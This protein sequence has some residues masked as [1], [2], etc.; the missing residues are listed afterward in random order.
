MSDNKD[1]RQQREEVKSNLRKI[2]KKRWFYPAVYLCAAALIMTGVLWLQ[3]S[4]SNN[5]A[6][7][8][9]RMTLYTSK[10]S[11]RILSTVQ[12]KS[13]NGRWRIKTL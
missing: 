3:S 13:L 4:H 1:E 5:Q 8:K 6:K 10:T 11:K 12:K 9:R 2:L 7:R